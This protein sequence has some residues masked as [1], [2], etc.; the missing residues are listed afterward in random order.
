MP[1]IHANG[2]NFYYEQTGVGPDLVCISGLSCDHTMWDVRK[3]S[4]K[5]RV[6][7]F[8]N[9][10]VGQSEVPH[11][12]YTMEAFVEDTVALCHAL[13]IKKAHFLGHSMGGHIAQYV[14]ALHPE[15]VDK[16]VLACSEPEISVISYIATKTQ[17]DL[18]HHNIPLRLL[19]ET[20]L[21]VLFSIEYL[22]DK[23]RVEQFI[24][25][26]M[27]NPYPQSA[28]GYIGQVEALRTHNTK[29]LLSKIKS[30]TLVLG[31]KDDLLTPLK[32]SEYLKNHISH[33][34]LTVIDNCGHVPFIE[35]PKEFWKIILD[36]L[37]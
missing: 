29:H 26:T 3:F 35:K 5:F 2:L 32:N 9:R 12:H 28:K 21:P 23:R 22:E 20:F 31:C 4:D 37:L 25:Q 34:L 7:V 36:F 14:A 10:G 15:L 13:G 24:T 11:Q 8:D 18:R 33:A 6:L 19:I 27:S 30:P 17:I 1:K 16:L